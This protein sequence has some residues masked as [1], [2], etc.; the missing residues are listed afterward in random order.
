MSGVRLGV[1]VKVVVVIVYNRPA[2]TCLVGA[3]WQE[4][5]SE[6]DRR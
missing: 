3:K 1:P 5:D 2:P 4:D 6:D